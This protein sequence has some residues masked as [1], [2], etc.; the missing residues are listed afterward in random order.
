MNRAA[1]TCG[2][3]KHAQIQFE[4]LSTARSGRVAGHQKRRADRFEKPLEEID[5]RGWN[6]FPVLQT[7]MTVT[8]DVG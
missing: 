2:K 7:P 3:S 6:V 8:L 5:G 4:R 1:G